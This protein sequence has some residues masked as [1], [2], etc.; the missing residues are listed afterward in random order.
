MNMDKTNIKLA[1]LN[2][3]GILNHQKRDVI[4]QWLHDRKYDIIC[5]QETFCTN[6]SKTAVDKSWKGVSYHCLSNSNHSR[7][8][9]VLLA[10]HF[11]PNII[12]NYNTN[13]GRILIINFELLG[14]TYSLVNVYAPSEQRQ[15]KQFYREWIKER[16][17]NENCLLICGYCI[18]L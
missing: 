3:R 16:V 12:N 13:D 10:P 14:Q 17:L 7:G 11:K 4:F 1:T 18:V 6:D 2:V 8:V 9:S 15:R 5:L